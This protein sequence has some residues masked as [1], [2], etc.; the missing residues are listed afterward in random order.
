MTLTGAGTGYGAPMLSMWK[1]AATAYAVRNAV[2]GVQ[3][4]IAG[5]TAPEAPFSGRHG[6]TDQVS[7][8]IEL[9][10]FGTGEEDFYLPRAKIKYWPVAHAMQ[11]AIWAGIELRKQVAADELASVDVQTC[12]SAC[13]PI[14]TTSRS[15][16]RCPRFCKSRGWMRADR[17]SDGAHLRSPCSFE[18]LDRMAAPSR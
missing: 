18:T 11:T 4:A 17:S 3:L 8:P 1:G 10:P 13:S 16:I 7:G 2:F 15:R 12:W 5:M 14:S 6:F 9:A